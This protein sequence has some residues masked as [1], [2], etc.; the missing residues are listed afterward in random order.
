MLGRGGMVLG[1]GGFVGGS[2]PPSNARV[3]AVRSGYFPSPH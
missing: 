1:L 2:T 3:T